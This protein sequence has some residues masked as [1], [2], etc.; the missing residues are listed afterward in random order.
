VSSGGSERE[1]RQAKAAALRVQAAKAEARRRQVLV[2][3]VVLVVL[4]LVVGVFVVIQNSRRDT[5]TASK[6]TPANLGTKNS[7]VVGQADAPV[8]LT[9]YEDFLCPICNQFEQLNGTQIDA[10][11]KAGTVKVEYRPV[12]ILDRN[13]TDE[14][15]TRSLNAAG[16]LVNSTPS[17]FPAFH[18]A[19][20]AQQPAEGGPGLTDAQL[21]DLAVTAGAPRAAMT[22]AVKDRTYEAWT[23]RATE[24]ASKDGLSGTPMVL[25]NG[26]LVEKWTAANLKAAVDAAAAAAK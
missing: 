19:L 7:I 16:A 18:K 14:Y 21:I 10:W 17:A 1:N 23:V 2:G 24:Q 5:S 26:K 8:T 25:V 20:F 9:A 13:S 3:S 6:A 4:V 15:S 11:L 12:A 22:T